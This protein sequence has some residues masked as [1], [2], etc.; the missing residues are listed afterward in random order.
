MEVQ[1]KHS[2]RLLSPRVTALITSM[3]EKGRVNAA[4][5]SFVYP[6]SFEPAMLI[7]GIAHGKLTLE[8]IKKT[9]EFVVNI[10]SEDFA[11]KALECEKKYGDFKE[12][13]KKSG[14]TLKE[15]AKVKVPKLNESKSVLECRLQEAVEVRECDHVI[16]VGKIVHAECEHM[17]GNSPKLDELDYL[18]HAMGSE[19]REVG[20][21]VLLERKK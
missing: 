11:Q 14:L 5:Y 3:D 21:K 2:A 1:L 19:F 8:N 12:R 6:I 20:K 9:K 4:P 7:A 13:I 10:V 16:V 15:S 17:Q 18:M